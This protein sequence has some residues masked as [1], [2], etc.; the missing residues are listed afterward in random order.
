MVDGALVGEV[1][2]YCVV[3]GGHHAADE[4]QTVAHLSLLV[5]PAASA[6]KAVARAVV[7]VCCDNTCG[8]D[9]QLIK[10]ILVHSVVWNIMITL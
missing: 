8:N 7:G 1:L 4:T 9:N 2:Q 10:L 3:T 6:V 5:V